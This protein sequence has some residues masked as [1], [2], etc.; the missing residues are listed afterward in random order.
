MQMCKVSS[1]GET[2]FVRSECAPEPMC[3][4]ATDQQLVDMERFCT[5]DASSVLSVD[6]TFNLGT[7]YATPTTYHVETVI[8][9]LFFLDMFSFIKRRPSDLF[10]ILRQQ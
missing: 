2:A 3:I 1:G 5:G 10:T 6:P 9:T 4:L 8:I 7:F